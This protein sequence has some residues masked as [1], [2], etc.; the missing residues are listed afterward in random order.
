MKAIWNIFKQDLANIKRVPLVGILLIGLAILPSLYAWLNLAASWDPYDNTD[1]VKVAVVNEDEGTE[2]EG[3]FVHVGDEVE[4]NLQEEGGLG[5]TFVSRDEAEEGVKYGDY[6]AAI[7]IPKDFSEGLVS[8]I[9]GSP[10]PAEI[11]YDV[12]EKLNAIAP[13]MTE[14][15]TTTIVNEVSS[16]FIQESSEALFTEFNR[17]GIALEEELPTIRAL[18]QQVYTLE[19]STP[20][21]MDIGDMVISIDEQW[22]DVES[23]VEQFQSLDELRPQIR[24]GVEYFLQLEQ[25][26]S[27]IEALGERIVEV[28]SYL[29]QINQSLE[30][31][32][33]FSE[34]IEVI[35]DEINEV[36]L[37]ALQL[38]EGISIVN[39][40]LPG[41]IDQ[42]RAMEEH[43]ST[44]VDLLVNLNEDLDQYINHLLEM[45]DDTALLLEEIEQALSQS[46]IEGVEARLHDLNDQ[47]QSYGLLLEDVI[48]QLEQWQS[49]D[50]NISETIEQLQTVQQHVQSTQ[51]RVEK[52]IEKLE[53]NEEV[54]EDWIDDINQT[55]EM[56][57]NNL[58]DFQYFMTTEGEEQI[59]SVF[60]QAYEQVY[61]TNEQLSNILEVLPEL[62]DHIDEMDRLFQI[63]EQELE[64]FLN[65]TNV[66]DDLVD[67]IDQIEETL[68]KVENTLSDVAHFMEHQFGDLQERIE[69]V[70]L[71]I[72]SDLPEVEAQYLSLLDLIDEHFPQVEETVQQLAQFA[73]ED[74]EDLNT[75]LSEVTERMREIEEEGALNELI[76]L[77]RYDV[78]E[79][80]DF[81]KEPV[82]LNENQ[83][84]SVPNYGSANAPFYTALSLWIGAL[85]LC[86]LLSTDVHRKDRQPHFKMHHMYLG[87]MILFLIVAVLQGIVISVGN[88]V[89]L[90]VHTQ[91]PWWFT[92]F[93]VLIAVVFML[94]VYTL[95]SVFGNIGKALAIVLLVLQLAGGGGMFPI[96]V[97]PNFFQ[98]IHPYLPFTYAVD[99]LREAVGGI[100]VSIAWFNIIMLVAF[101]VGTIVF[102]LLLKEKLAARIAETSEKS[103]SSR[104]ID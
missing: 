33:A 18:K 93:T 51:Q 7:Y 62:E 75:Q 69:G 47:L 72:R 10:N 94:M 79:E 43:T 86:N 36:A 91:S 77:L 9:D 96:E 48:A 53:Q 21:L 23:Q 39:D 88:I 24:E 29:P 90:G 27:E 2:V 76:V 34:Q 102:G 54:A 58:V 98:A 42:V 13:K 59:H 101:G 60:E 104:L 8:V 31:F 99:L 44:L 89:M 50:P 55:I 71:F 73:D 46:D 83:L 35:E 81:F 6:Y 95:T 40:N 49:V 85:L 14:T 57:N 63:D 38:Q 52:N 32:R 92:I 84:F 19:E 65:E 20:L 74:L 67:L 68:P 56:L 17:L 45:T 5:W 82:V 28:Q 64:T 1:D 70:A 15:G 97:A 30:E 87:R 100:I 103:K 78:E 37:V 12:N 26:L 22:G 25:N 41:V 80:S 11:H 4:A 16:Q 3:D 61:E 66:S